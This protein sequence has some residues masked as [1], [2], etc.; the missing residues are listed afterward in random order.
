MSMMSTIAKW[1]VNLGV[2]LITSLVRA[3]AQIS[4]VPNA[5]LPTERD[6]IC[7]VGGTL[8]K[9]VL[10]AKAK[11]KVHGFVQK[12]VSPVWEIL[13]MRPKAELPCRQMPIID[14]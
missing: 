13:P 7:E 14:I 6:V 8:I 5:R 10:K 1:I 11:R 3:A 9:S 12:F 2:K 4:G